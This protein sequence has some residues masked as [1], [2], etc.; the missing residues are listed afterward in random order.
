LD[1][2]ENIY[3]IADHMLDFGLKFLAIK[4]IYAVF[5]VSDTPVYCDPEKLKTSMK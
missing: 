5:V 2:A 3:N 4:R 1:I